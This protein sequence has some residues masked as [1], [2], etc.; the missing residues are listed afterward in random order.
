[1]NR[2]E[3]DTEVI[4]PSPRR[5]V[6]READVYVGWTRRVRARERTTGR[7]SRP[8][9][10]SRTGVDSPVSTGKAGFCRRD[11]LGAAKGWRVEPVVVGTRIRTSPATWPASAK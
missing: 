3:P 4:E 8:R 5:S 2:V 7:P 11:R 1:V 9:H 10:A 6:A